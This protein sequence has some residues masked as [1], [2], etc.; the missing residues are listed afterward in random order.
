MKFFEEFSY[1]SIGIRCV[2]QD[3]TCRMSGVG[4]AGDGPFGQ[5][6]YI[7]KGSGLPRIDV[8]G[9]RHQVS[10]NTLIRQLKNITA[11]GAPVVN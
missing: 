4:P 11:S 1:N 2:L 3:G 5:G 10:W 9:Y 6:Y 7:V 8:V